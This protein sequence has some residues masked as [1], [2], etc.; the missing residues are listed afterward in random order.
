MWEKAN[1]SAFGVRAAA[2]NLLQDWRAA[3][4]KMTST[5]F[6]NTA[7]GE[8]SK[9]PDEWIKIN[10]DATGANNGGVGIGCH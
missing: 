8:W 1:E 10:V 2:Y 7:N 3:Q 9:P 4:A 6:L 5:I